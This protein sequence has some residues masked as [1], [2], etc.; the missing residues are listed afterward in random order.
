MRIC[1]IY[2]VFGGAALILVAP[3][4]DFSK[5]LAIVRK[6]PGCSKVDLITTDWDRDDSEAGGSEGCQKLLTKSTVLLELGE[7]RSARDYRL[8]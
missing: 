8:V 4:T 2:L 6:V 1:S 5:E 3:F 7:I